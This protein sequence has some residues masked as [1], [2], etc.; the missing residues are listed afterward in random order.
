M[1]RSEPAHSIFNTTDRELKNPNRTCKKCSLFNVRPYVNARAI[2]LQEI[3][4]PF[5]KYF[6]KFSQ[7]DFVRTNYGKDA[8]SWVMIFAPAQSMR[9]ALVTA[10]FQLRSES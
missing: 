10:D 6:T 4:P 1:H 8:A 5:I 3:T 9:V 2:G 7:S